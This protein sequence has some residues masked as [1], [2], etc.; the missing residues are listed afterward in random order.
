MDTL[1]YQCPIDLPPSCELSPG[2]G[3]DGLPSCC[4]EGDNGL[5]VQSQF[6]MG[7]NLKDLH[8]ANP[9]VLGQKVFSVVP[10][11]HEN[12]NETENENV[13][14]NG[15]KSKNGFT[16]HGLWPD[17][18][19]GVDF[20]AFCRQDLFIDDVFHLLTDNREAN[21]SKARLQLFH[22]MSLYWPNV[23]RPGQDEW[24][25]I[26][27]FNKHGTCMRTIRPECYGGDK[28]RAVVDY[29]NVTVD[30]FKK[31][32]SF[33]F[34]K[35]RG[36]VPS[37]ER[38]YTKQELEDA[39]SAGFGG[40]RVFIDCDPKTNTLKEVWYFNHVKGPLAR[41][42]FVPVGVDELLKQPESK[43]PKSGIWYYPKL[44]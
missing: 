44:K 15:T 34:L 27:E 10:P 30:L 41:R 43:C 33:K 12:E 16:I 13:R 19:T 1:L 39:L 38:N 11:K 3:H 9:S 20:D 28:K 35:D 29:F 32:D 23:F 26:H 21:D 40:K 2:Q 36:I 14:I 25:W 37:Y 17:K 18:C 4:S 24:L 5:F 7:T 22:D 8:D 6:W 31:L 42:Q